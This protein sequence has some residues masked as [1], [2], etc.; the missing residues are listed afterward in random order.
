ME[1]ENKPKD[2]N[3]SQQRIK[4]WNCKLSS[5][6]T[7][8][9]YLT[10]GI[11]A[12]LVGVIV[13]Y[14]AKSVKEHR[15]QYNQLDKCKV[16]S[17]ESCYVDFDI[18]SDMHGDVFVYYEIH[19]LYQNHRAYSK[20]LSVEQMIGDSIKKSEAK[21]FCDPIVEIKDL[22]FNPK[23]F[24]SDKV[25]NPCGLISDSYF[26]DTFLLRDNKNNTVKIH[27]DDIAFEFDKD[28]KF[29]GSNDD[30]WIDVKN[31]NGYLEHFIVWTSIASLP[32]FRKLWGRIYGLDKGQYRMFIESS[33][34]VSRFSGKKFVVLSTVSKLGGKDLVLGWILVAVGIVAVLGSFVF[35]AEFY[36]ERKYKN[37]SVYL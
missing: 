34:D 17:K 33:Y 10:T 16:D 24:S 9:F 28:E 32:W 36:C 11:I 29:K 37:G 20:S 26:T 14:S 8:L 31:G 2:S 3:L 21:K 25:A 30:R 35:L 15:K 1:L 4:A 7:A 22:H 18:D 23:N 6:F 27:E 12:I 5:R 13:I 19:G